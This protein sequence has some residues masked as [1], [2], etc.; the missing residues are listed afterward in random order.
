MRAAIVIA[1][2]SSVAVGGT[3]DDGIDPSAYLEYADGFA[4]YTASLRAV[5]AAGKPQFATATLI[6]D[7]WA[8]TAAHV[9]HGCTEV[10]LRSGDA[11]WRVDEVV[12]H[13]DWADRLGEFDIAL[14]RTGVP[15]RRGFYPPLATRRHNPGSVVSIAGYGVTGQMSTGYGMA[16]GRLRAGTNTIERYERQMLICRLRRR[17]SPLEFGIAPGDSGG[18]LFCDGE[19]AGINSATFA[20]RGPLLS[21]EGEES[22]HTAVFEFVPWIREVIGR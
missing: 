16:D 10:S 14:L 8:L 3:V 9:V 17:S 5:N 12:I 21:R 7:H 20:D 6:D 1:A 13:K 4:G 2:A 19:L 22:G 18:P 15:M 11:E